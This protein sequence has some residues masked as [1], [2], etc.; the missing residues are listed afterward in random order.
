[1]YLSRYR[2]GQGQGH[3]CLPGPACA[4]KQECGGKGSLGEVCENSTLTQEEYG[5]RYHDHLLDQYKLFVETSQHVSDRRQ[6]ANNYLLTLT[7]SLVLL[8]ITFLST[9]GHHWWNVFIPVTGV[10]VCFIWYS[11]VCSYKDLNTAKFVVIH[12]LEE[13]LPVSLFKYEWHVC[14]KGKKIGYVPLTHLERGIP[15]A[16]AILFVVLGVHAISTPAK[17]ASVPVG[18]DKFAPAEVRQA[19]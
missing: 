12:E 5:D 19:R 8:Y 18:S 6:N 7:S 3:R 10:V 2:V 1:M 4:R 11:L 13:Q 15:I 17:A 16:F 14:G 9:F